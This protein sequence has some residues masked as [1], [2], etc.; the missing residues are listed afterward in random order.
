MNYFIGLLSG[1]SVDGIDSALVAIDE[2]SIHLEATYCQVF[3]EE[4]RSELLYLMHAPSVTLKSLSKMDAALA[5][6][7]SSA[8][9][10]LLQV[11]GKKTDEIIAIGS[12]GQTLFHQP[13]GKLRNTMQIGS[14]HIIAAECGINVVSNF[15]NMDM[16]YG[17]QGA[18]LA[19]LIHEKLFAN[20]MTNI[21]AVNL[22]GIAN[23]SL[24]GKNYKSPLGF[25]TGPANCLI[26]EWIYNNLNQ[27][28]DENGNWAQSGKLDAMLLEKMLEDP[29]FAKPSPKSTGR[30]YFNFHWLQQFELEQV[31][32]VDIQTT[33][34]HLTAIT[35]SQAVNNI[36]HEINEIVLM[37]G[38]A[39]NQ[40][41]R[42]LIESY[43]EIDTVTAE[44]KG[45]KSDWIEA[46]LFAYLAYKRVSN[47]KLDLA[48]IT[49]S[50]S[51]TLIGDIIKVR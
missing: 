25:D 41:M 19:P 49:G 23:I 32:A 31:S 5:Y 48:S 29:Y 18:P 8:V 9:K 37:G 16:A 11:S 27:P 40:Y 36:P 3:P 30:E 10:S 4:L 21:A 24:I 44:N 33:L 46:M 42:K 35:V 43:S 14:P 34:T 50:V 28:F 1:T 22:G 17:G 47:Q 51:Q 15:R 7:F 26:D 6:E 13:D 38:G 12:H 2:E 20:S 39:K 45:Y